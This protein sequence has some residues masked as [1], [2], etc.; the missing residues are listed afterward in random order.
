MITVT[1]DDEQAATLELGR[2]VAG[3][4]PRSEPDHGGHVGRAG[5]VERGATAHRV[6]DEPDGQVTE[7]LLQLLERP[8]G[9][10][11][12]RLL[13]AVPAANPVAQ[14]GHDEPVLLPRPGPAGGRR[15]ACGPRPADGDGPGRC[16]SPG[17]RAARA[18]SCA[19]RPVRCRRSGRARSSPRSV[20]ARATFRFTG[21]HVVLAGGRAEVDQVVV[22]VVV[23]ARAALQV[24]RVP[25][26]VP[27]QHLGV[28]HRPGKVDRA[29]VRRGRVVDVADDEHGVAAWPPWAWAPVCGRV[30]TAGS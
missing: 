8:L 26:P 28:T 25:L 16:C 13:L 27:R 11:H 6:T 5:H 23:N 7:S 2:R 3:L 9:V 17:H 19:A 15:A 21:W 1:V 20:P 22:H 24:R 30:A 12:R 4:D 18:R 10:G 14:P 29:L